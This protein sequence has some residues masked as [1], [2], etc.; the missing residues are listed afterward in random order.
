MFE[1]NF[2]ILKYFKNFICNVEIIFPNELFLIHLLLFAVCFQEV[3]AQG[4]PQ[5]PII[6][7]LPYFLIFWFFLSLHL[8]I[9]PFN[10][11]ISLCRMC[12]F[13]FSISCERQISALSFFLICPSYCYLCIIFKMVR[14]KYILDKT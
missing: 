7:C 10:H 4:S 8:P 11:K 12:P 5:L 9:F 3:N 14:D 2:G 1:V 13:S 6:C